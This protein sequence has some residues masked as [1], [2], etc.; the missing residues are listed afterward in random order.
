MSTLPTPTVEKPVTPV[1]S[2]REINF[3]ATNSPDLAPDEFKLG[4]RTF[5]VMNLRYD[6][7]IAFLGYLK[8][9]LDGIGKAIVSS[10]GIKVPEIEI[11]PST[12]NAS[13]LFQFCLKDLPAMV[14]IVC[15]Q[16]DKT[17]TVEQ[18]KE[19][20]G[21]PFT[22]CEIVIKQI[23]RNQMIAHFSSFFA[24]LLPILARLGLAQKMAKQ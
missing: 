22:L 6:D 10:K 3:A 17:V 14:R 23:V 21:E 7:Y 9:F 4:E 20:A 8:P 24:H 19:W 13:T 12:L 2:E 16:T 11:N 18:I 15:A 5:K 1:L